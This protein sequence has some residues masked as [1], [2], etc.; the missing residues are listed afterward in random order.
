MRLV[1][2]ALLTSVLLAGCGDEVCSNLENAR[3]A[4][5]TKLIPCNGSVD[6]YAF[7]YD[8]TGS[9]APVFKAAG[10]LLSGDYVSAGDSS[11]C[12]ASIGKCSS[13]EQATLN[14]FASC[15]EALPDCSSSTSQAFFNAAYLCAGGN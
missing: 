8:A 5:N 6:S 2:S 13:S 15:F 1:V 3:T 14:T 7:G 9:C 12:D 11:T 10:I 4:L